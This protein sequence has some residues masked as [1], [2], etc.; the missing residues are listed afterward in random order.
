M[1]AIL[2]LLSAAAATPAPQ[3]QSQPPGQQSEAPGRPPDK[4]NDAKKAPPLSMV[5]S[6]TVTLPSPAAGSLGFDTTQ[7]YVPTRSSELVALSLEDGTVAWTVP[8]TDIVGPPATGDGLVFVAHARQVEALDARTAASRW[9]ATVGGPVSAPLLWQNGWLLAATKQGDAIMFRAATG[10]VLWKQALGSAVRV[11]P[12]AAD[13]RVYVLLEDG[14]VA[15]LA[16]ATGKTIWEATLPGRGTMIYPLDD[17]IFVGSADKFFYCLAA[18]TGKRKWRWRTGGTIVGTAAVDDD[19]VYFVS[20]DGI[21]RALDRSNGHQAW[22]IPLPHRPTG[23]PFLSGRRLL[24]PGMSAE[25]PAFHAIDGSAAGSAKLPGEPAVPPA[26]LP[27]PDGKVGRMMVVAGEGQAQLLVP[28]LPPLPGKPIP[29]LP[30]FSLPPEVKGDVPEW[31]D[32]GTPTE[33]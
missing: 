32:P 16:L 6:W 33:F 3:P 1:I 21:L 10:E 9:R 30:K 20:L 27:G 17:R 28:G 31:V 18:D 12:A 23:G 7:A 26:W 13:D 11:Q 2:F 14:R 29:G 5:A 4:K 22:K 8:L 25:V 19:L 15:A 24:V